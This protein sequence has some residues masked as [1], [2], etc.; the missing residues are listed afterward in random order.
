MNQAA[1][2]QPDPATQA[3]AQE[4]DFATIALLEK[5][6]AEDATDDPEE[7]RQAEEELAAFKEAMNRNRSE[8]GEL[9][10]FP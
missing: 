9:P 10:L 1:N 4:I 6:M 5:W 3:A 8:S 7:I 2:A